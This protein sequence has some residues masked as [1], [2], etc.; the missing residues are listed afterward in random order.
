M[1]ADHD[2]SV[3]QEHGRRTGTLREE[4]GDRDALYALLSG[5]ELNMK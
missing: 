2:R 4:V 1:T 5:D 3:S